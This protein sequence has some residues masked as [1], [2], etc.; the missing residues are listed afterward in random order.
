MTRWSLPLAMM[1][2]IS[3]A[4]MKNG[5]PLQ[6]ATAVPVD[7]SLLELPGKARA[8]GEYVLLDPEAW[9][10]YQKIYTALEEYPGVCQA[11]LDQCHEAGVAHGLDRY[12]EGLQ[13][14]SEG[15]I[16]RQRA[17]ILGGIVAVAAGAVGA[18]WG[19]FEG[20]RQ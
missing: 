13:D 7:P 12:H 17:A 4:G 3:C 11:Q 5:P 9:R 2:T 16:T 20:R 18:I 19:Y 1:L 14:G 6:P 10:H 15:K 8:E